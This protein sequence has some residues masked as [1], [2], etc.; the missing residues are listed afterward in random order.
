M[1]VKE[2]SDKT[3]K[4]HALIILAVCILFGFISLIRKSFVMA[5]CTIAVGIIVPVV[6]L[7]LMKNVSKHTKGTF[8][9]LSVAFIIAGLSS[10]QGELHSMFAL[11]A[12]NIAIASIYYDLRN[13]KTA[14]ALTNIILIAACL[15]KDF[16]YVGASVGLII[17]GILG[18]NIA[19]LMVYLLLQD[20]ITSLQEATVA[21]QKADALLGQVQTQ[22]QETHIMAEKQTAT[23]NQIA[24]V[25]QNLEISSHNMLDIA[26]RLDSASQEQTNAISE[27]NSNIEKFVVQ[28]DDCFKV[29]EKAQEAATLSVSMLT[30]NNESMQ[31]LINAMDRL[32]DTSRQIGGIIKTIEDISFQTNILALNASV[33]AARA[34]AAGKG[35]AVVADEVRNLAAKSAEAAKDSANL[36][37]ASIQAVND[38]TTYVQLAAGNIGEILNYS[39][40]SEEQA[41]KFAQLAYEQQQ[42]VYEI[43]NH[44]DEIN[45]IVSANTETASESAFMARSLANNVEEMNQIISK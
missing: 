1:T 13:I 3:I 12:G 37:N 30:E 22:M 41:K 36:I 44:I 45:N 28:T 26:E 42:D 43:K 19:A 11:L 34:G 33:E 40:Q 20:C 16:V 23:V 6:V 2:V 8:L 18:L 15:F 10:L 4:M 7:I 25:A 32:N 39:R 29:S 38:S 31:Q 17:K 27:I 35:F 21:T 9:T 5:F 14:W 24:D